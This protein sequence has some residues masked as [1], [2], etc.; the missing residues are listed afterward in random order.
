MRGTRK[1]SKKL[2]QVAINKNSFECQALTLSSGTE[3]TFHVTR[4]PYSWVG[5]DVYVISSKPSINL[6]INKLS[7]RYVWNTFSNDY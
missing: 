7:I 3:G 1:R 2:E 5:C 6:L 4:T